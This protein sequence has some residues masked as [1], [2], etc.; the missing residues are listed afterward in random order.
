MFNNKRATNKQK[1]SIKVKLIITALAIM[2]LALGSTYAW[3]TV[4]KEVSST[5]TMGFLDVKASFGAFDP[6]LNLEPGLTSEAEGIISNTGSIPV[7][8]RLENSSSIKM[9]GTNSFVPDEDNVVKINFRPTS[10]LWDD[11]MDV[12]WMQHNENE[13]DLLLVMEENAEVKVTNEAEFDGDK[14]GNEYMNAQVKVSG[15][16]NGT[17]V[18]EGAIEKELGINLDDY[19]LMYSAR[20][21]SARSIGGDARQERLNQLLNR[22]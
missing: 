6:E 13:D 11:Q 17:Q 12:Y 7:I 15:K 22:K 18:I 3:W 20:A 9:E 2:M 5:V 19:H 10:G 4:Q 1:V 16:L 14:I 21:R 8:V